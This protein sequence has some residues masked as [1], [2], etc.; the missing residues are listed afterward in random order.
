RARFVDHFGAVVRDVAIAGP[1]RPFLAALVFPNIEALRGL[2]GLGAE[3]TVEALLASPAVTGHFRGKLAELAKE[4]TGS[5]TLIERLLLVD[6]PPSL[7]SGELTDKGSLNQ[8]AVLA[9]RA[10]LVEELYR[11]SPRVIALRT[12][13][14]GTA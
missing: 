11:G 6:P 8:R 1:D 7:D 10:G 13:D 4:S 14:P 3:A 5:S 2:S 9:G 12:F